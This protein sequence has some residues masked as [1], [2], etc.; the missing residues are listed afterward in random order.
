MK[1]VASGHAKKKP[2][3]LSPQ[4]A[5]EYVSSQPTPKGLPKQAKKKGGKK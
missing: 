3:G 4:E 1:A 5:S 2:K